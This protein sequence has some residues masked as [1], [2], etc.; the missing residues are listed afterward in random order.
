M[1]SKLLL[2]LALPAHTETPGHSALAMLKAVSNLPDVMVECFFHG[3]EQLSSSQDDSTTA[4][5]RWKA[6]SFM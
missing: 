6:H 2:H 5:S 3:F 1:M 4:V